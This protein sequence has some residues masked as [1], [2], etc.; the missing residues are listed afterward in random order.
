MDCFSSDNVHFSLVI[1][2]HVLNTYS[3]N[4]NVVYG[5]FRRFELSER[6]VNGVEVF[7]SDLRKT[8]ALS[9]PKFA[10]SPL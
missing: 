2:S 10:A 1:A 3:Y 9:V 4:L 7:I 8:F 6:Y 5:Q